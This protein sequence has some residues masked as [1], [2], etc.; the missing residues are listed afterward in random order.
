MGLA[1]VVRYSSIVI[2]P[3]R[4]D[5]VYVAAMGYEWGRNSERG[6]FKT[7]DGG[8]TWNKILYINDTTGFIDLQA[9]PKN[10]DML[11]AAAWQRFRFG[12]GDMAESGPESGLYK[13]TDGGKKWTKLTNGLPKEDK[14]KITVAV[15]R[16][17]PKIVYAA[18]LT[19]EPAP[20]GKRT[21]DTGGIF[22][23]TDGGKAGSA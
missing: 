4:P 17:N 9:D 14:G 10:P 23:S 5:T 2:H 11:Y 18:I 20:G 16:N 3:T 7:I 15:A 19:G 6:I 21:I 12:G 8:K 1:T 13:T 22:R